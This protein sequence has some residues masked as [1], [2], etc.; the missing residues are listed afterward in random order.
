MWQFVDNEL[1]RKTQC[2]WLQPLLGERLFMYA[3]T[4]TPAATRAAGG[5]SIDGVGNYFVA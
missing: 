1:A 5:I 3:S 2:G 4:E